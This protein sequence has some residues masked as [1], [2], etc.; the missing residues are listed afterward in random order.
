VLLGGY[1]VTQLLYVLAELGIPDLLA[2][3]ALGVEELAAQTKAHP[4][5]LRRVLRAHASLGVLAEDED[6]RFALTALGER[7]RAHVP[8]SLQPLALA[9]GI[10]WRWDA[11]G[12]LIESVRTGETAF[13]HAHGVPLYRFLA[14]HHDAASD[15]NSHMA[16]LAE[17]RGQAI[18]EAYDFSNTRRLVDVGG[19]QGALVESI[20]SANEHV[21]AVVFDAPG[22]VVEAQRRLEL[23]GL[24][25][26]VTFESGDF[27]VS[28]PGGGDLYTLSNVV[29]DWD[30]R[31]A[32]AILRNCREA[33]TGRALLLIVQDL[34]PP[35]NERSR[36]NVFDISLLV[37]TGGHERTLDEY[38]KLLAAADLSL[39]RVVDTATGT[40]VLEAAP[41]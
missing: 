3:G 41:A 39:Q 5:S 15:F 11:W 1:E 26:R 13:E 7:L 22:A 30:D 18:A 19:G 27:F 9:Y 29:H 2:G 4:A 38:R 10:R 21:E 16:V 35:G 12:H 31:E 6:E 36:V 8:G 17:E 14:E 37:L 24:S 32:V 23:A 20:L 28:V 40:S 25:Q 34:V 33:M